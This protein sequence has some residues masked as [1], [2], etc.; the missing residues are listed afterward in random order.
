MMEGGRQ[1]TR[2]IPA[3]GDTGRPSSARPGS[4]KWGGVKVKQRPSS[5]GGFGRASGR[6]T[7]AA[8]YDAIE[9]ARTSDSTHF[10]TL[11]TGSLKKRPQS[12]AAL[13]NS[14][15]K[16]E[17]RDMFVKK[18]A[19]REVRHHTAMFGTELA[20]LEK[21]IE[22][23]AKRAAEEGGGKDDTTERVARRTRG[24]GEMVF[25][26][27]L[28]GT[29]NNIGALKKHLDLQRSRNFS[30]VRPEAGTNEEGDKNDWDM[31]EKE[32]REEF[33]RSMRALT[34]GPRVRVDKE[35]KVV[36]VPLSFNEKKIPAS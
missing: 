1:R 36:G 29:G 13:P 35:K 22:L 17:V 16:M 28:G 15:S 6:P 30:L 11:F 14:I 21:E 32:R 7:S 4:A 5:G 33:E 31:V 12:A 10:D 34:K 20:R 23:E 8:S 9:A 27:N 19:Q 26:K 25:H 18:G 2:V 3:R 24:R